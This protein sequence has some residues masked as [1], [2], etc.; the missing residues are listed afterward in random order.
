MKSFF[1]IP[2]FKQKVTNK[3]FA[4][5]KRF[6]TQKGFNVLMVPIE[7]DH[8]TMTDYTTQFEK[9]FDKNK[10]KE[11][12]VF[13]FSYGAAI[14][15]ITAQKLKPKKIF[16]CSLSPDFKEDLI[17]QKKWILDY[18]GKKR[19]ADNM[20]RSGVKIANNLSIPSI[21]FYGERE[22]KQYPNLKNRCEE[23]VKLAK[24]SRCIVVKDAP[25]NISHP[26]YVAAIKAQF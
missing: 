11:N 14:T 1:I 24:N 21:V 3:D 6:L 12:Y 4:W 9:F 10:S 13:G 20:Q 22:G 5:L 7:W 25:H 2:G 19:V 26:E 16:L 18:I 17:Y 15:F 8:K 23:T